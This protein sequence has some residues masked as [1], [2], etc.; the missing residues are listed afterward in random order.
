MRAH[1][2]FQLARIALMS[3][4]LIA[5]AVSC[6]PPQEP[7]EKGDAPEPKPEQIVKQPCC[8][9]PQPGA[10]S[11]AEDIAA[12]LAAVGSGDLAKLKKLLASNPELVNAKG[13][14]G[15]TPLNVALWRANRVDAAKLL[16]ASGADVN[17][18]KKGTASTPLHWAATSGNV[19]F[20]KLLISKG[21]DV[22]AKALGGATPLKVATL[23][24]K[25]AVAD[26]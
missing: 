5:G 12:V 19:E 3:V 21:A 16:I 6:S 25:K 13:K 20:A 15:E 4:V 17:A 10:S 11:S 23:L 26:L 7:A 9:G 24:R 22:N 2:V 1:I 8:P 18:G 14:S